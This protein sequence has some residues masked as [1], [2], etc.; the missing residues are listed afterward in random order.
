MPADLTVAIIPALNEVLNLPRVL[1]EIPRGE[2]DRVM[3]GVDVRKVGQR[4][5]T[6]ENAEN[7][8]FVHETP[9]ALRTLR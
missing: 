4:P 7:A 6:A 9:R 8:E 2:V 3:V 1:A 5:F